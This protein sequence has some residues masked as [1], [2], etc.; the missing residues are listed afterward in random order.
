MIPI[1][2]L[3]DDQPFRV[4]YLVIAGGGGGTDP[5]GGGGGG[6]GGYIS[7]VPGSM[8]GENTSPL[9][10]IF[11]LGGQSVTITVGAGGARQT[12]GASSVFDSITAI[13]GGRGG[14]RDPIIP[15]GDGGSGGGAAPDFPEGNGTTAQGFSG[16]PG[17]GGGSNYPTTYR[18]GGGG[19]VAE[20]GDTDGV[21]AGGDGLANPIT[22]T[23]VVR[24]GG[25]G[26]SAANYSGLAGDGGGG[27]GAIRGGVSTAGQPN[28][29]GGG[30]GGFVGGFSNSPSSP[31][32]SGVVIL[33]YDSRARIINRIDPGL[34]FAFSDDGT[35]KRYVFTAGTG[36]ITF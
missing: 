35:F 1:Y 29:G 3:S 18:A 20:L 5:N 19:G 11:F 26:G 25:G 16:G 2:L 32:G 30:G 12:N 36:N 22:G 21:S 28:T 34:T 8:S 17:G 10:T 33:R 4:D 27:T 15:A 23:S 9:E 31:G 6:A 24:G 14:G 13:G 7:G